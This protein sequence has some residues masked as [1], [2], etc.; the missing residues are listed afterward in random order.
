MEAES[1]WLAGN[2]ASRRVSETLG[3]V[4]T[5]TNEQ[6][7]RDV[8]VIEQVVAIRR[9]AWVSPVPVEIVGLEPCLPLFGVT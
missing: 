5:R 1:G 4:R 9:E 2:D 7:P 6:R 3:Y 8:P